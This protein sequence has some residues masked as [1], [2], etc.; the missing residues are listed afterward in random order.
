M[1]CKFKKKQAEQAILVPSQEKFRIKGNKKKE[2]VHDLITKSMIWGAE[3]SIVYLEKS[4]LV[5]KYKGIKYAKQ[6]IIM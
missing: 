4:N 2:E 3:I 6:T 5:S 1:I